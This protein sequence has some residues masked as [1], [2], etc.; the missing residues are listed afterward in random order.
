MSRRK[1]S[2]EARIQKIKRQLEELGELRPGSLSEQ[3]NVCGK[4][5]CQCKA[6]PPKKHGPYYQ[7]SFTRHGKSRTQFVRREDLPRVRRELRNYERLRKLVD[8]WID[9]SLQLVSLDE[10]RRS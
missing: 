7:L 10:R 5:G 9:L 6:K 3:Y 8:Q 1:R 4:R 2:L